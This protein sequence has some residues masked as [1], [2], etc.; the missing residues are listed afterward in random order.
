[1][2][3]DYVPLLLFGGLALIF[4]VVTLWIGR[5]LRP[6][7]QDIGHRLRPYECGVPP[8]GDARGRFGVRYYV[9]AILFV[10]FDVEVIFLFPWAVQYDVLGLFGLVEM[11][12]FLGILI[13]GYFWLYKK[14]ALEWV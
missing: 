5:L 11:L 9:I 2:P 1:M 13:I 6:E 14:G 12:I 3:E 10:I 7:A 8:E 4:P